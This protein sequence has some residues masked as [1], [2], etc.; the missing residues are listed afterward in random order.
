MA[1]Q[2]AR[3]ASRGSRWFTP[4]L[5]V[6]LEEL[7][8]H[9]DRDWFDRNKERYVAHVRDPMLRFI[10]D[11]APALARV[12][13]RLVADPRPVGGSL[14]RIHRDTRFSRDK[15]PYKTNAAASF[16]HEAGRDVHGPGLYVSLA[17]GEIEGGGG[18]WR[19]EAEPLRL[20]RASIVERPAAWRRALAAPGLSRLTWWGESL[21]RTPRAFPPDH[22]LDA[23]LRRKDFA[24]GVELSEREALSAG[25]L[26]RCVEAWRPLGPVLKLLAGAVGLPW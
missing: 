16:R 18:M 20:V 10:A 17:P 15:T 6:F 22:P 21:A 7:R 4:E 26:D 12:A 19:P 5:F 25:F 24:A 2:G 1:H 9:N 14:F 3:R 23:W 8:L 13:P 11:V